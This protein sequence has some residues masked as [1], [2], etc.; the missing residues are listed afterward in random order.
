MPVK[1]I[2]IWIAGFLAVVTIIILLLLVGLP[3]IVEPQLQNRL[4]R[5]AGQYP[6]EF[7][8]EKLGVSSTFISDIR[9]AE[10]ISVDGLDIQYAVGLSK[11]PRVKKITVSGLTIHAQLDKE[12]QIHIGGMILKN[13]AEQKTRI[14]ISPFLP[15]LPEKL[16]L[17]NATLVLDIK[18]QEFL[19]PLE[20]L[21]NIQ[22]DKGKIAVMA[23]VYPF[24]EKID[25]QVDYDLEKGIERIIIE[26]KSFDLGH[27]D[28]F[29]SKITDKARIA[30]PVD[31]TLSSSSPQKKWELA[32]S[33]ILIKEPLSASL[34]NIST[35]VLI[36]NQRLSVQGNLNLQY[37]A[38]P[39]LP[40]EYSAG[41]DLKDM[42]AFD[43][44]I[45]T[46]DIKTLLIRQESGKLSLGSP[47]AT[48]K[49]NGTSEAVTG[50]INMNCKKGEFIAKDKKI[51]FKNSLLVLNV[52]NALKSKGNKMHIK[53]NFDVPYMAYNGEH[54]FATR[55]KIVQTGSKQ[56]AV[57]G[58][59]NI[60][61]LKQ[62]KTGFN[63]VVGLEDKL[64]V[65]AT[66]D[67]APFTLTHKDIKKWL[68]KKIK[69]GKFDVIVAVSGNAAWADNQL[70]T[71]MVVDLKNGTFRFPDVKFTATGVNASIQF[72]DLIVPETVPGQILTI[73]S[74]VVNKVKISDVNVRF[75]IEDAASVL[76]ESIRFK[77][78]NGIVAT[79]AIRFPQQNNEY[80][81]SLYCDRLDMTQLLAQIG[82]FK[83]EGKGTLNGRIP[84]RYKEGDIFFD[85]GFLFSTPGSGGKIKVYNT[86]VITAGIPL[87]SPQFSSLDL[88][89][90]ALKDFDYQWAKLS[91]NTA[92]DVLSVNM[93]LD[94]KPMGV[95]P[96]E[97]K[98]EIGRF[99]R[100]DAK[101]PG[102]NFQGI[103]LDVNLNLPF[104]EVMK[105]GN[106]LKSILK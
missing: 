38:I 94:G 31:F 77:W 52:S 9:I 45:K 43:A 85:N 12:N 75:S 92:G 60:D 40:L 29:I 103:K 7:K 95:M 17:K 19:I 28:Q 51:S 44:N 42:R 34:D 106:K 50:K 49:F 102:S 48:I 56:F 2:V 70:K 36:D 66:F 35:T 76:A 78:C 16:V 90:E 87:D 73:D 91:F 104:N 1:K 37:S 15:Y 46:G 13:S 98:K 4:P 41:F 101:S 47:Q 88:A 6:I 86:D 58:A 27:L 24:G 57:T 55:G 89:R 10:G 23:V 20:A 99:I 30:G 25:S 39:S 74:V 22:A 11:T 14:D 64:K 3:A 62:V 79:E 105:F 26:G 81:I 82:A 63:M 100:V 21:S 59:L 96:F 65:N 32:V 33:R 8:I 71:A 80:A 72:N 54:V 18:G 69:P 84:L 67:A 68:P 53:G 97:Y 61:A 83:A 5:I 93:E